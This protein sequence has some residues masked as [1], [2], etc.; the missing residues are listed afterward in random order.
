MSE[1]FN[2]NAIANV[3]NFEAKQQIAIAVAANFWGESWVKT[4]CAPC[5]PQAAKVL[6]FAP[7]PT[8]QGHNSDIATTLGGW[9]LAIGAQ[10]A[11]PSLAWP[12]TS[13]TSHSSAST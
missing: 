12:G 8:S 9:D 11:H 13:P 5:W 4:M 7:L 2:P 3:P 6:G 10:T 1:L